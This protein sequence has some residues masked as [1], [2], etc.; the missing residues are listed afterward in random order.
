[1][2]WHKNRQIRPYAESHEYLLRPSPVGGRP[3]LA[4]LR[5]AATRQN[6]QWPLRRR[7]RRTNPQFCT[8]SSRNFHFRRSPTTRHTLP[9]S[10]YRPMW[11]VWTTTKK[12]RYQTISYRKPSQCCFAKIYVA[13]VHW[14]GRQHPT[15]ATDDCVRSLGAA[16]S[17]SSSARFQWQVGFH[18]RSSPR[19]TD[20][21][22]MPHAKLPYQPTV[23]VLPPPGTSTVV[24]VGTLCSEV[25]YLQLFDLS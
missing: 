11:N 2:A 10:S 16:R 12:K 18:Q 6:E 19:P 8:R 20:H 25:R 1:M 7:R 4:F 13:F 9:S 3:F 24:K 14:N 5:F 23:Y 17:S 21:A 22:A 15:V